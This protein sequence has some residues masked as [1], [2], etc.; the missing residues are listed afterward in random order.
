MANLTI[1]QAFNMTASDDYIWSPQS[2]NSTQIVTAANGGAIY[3]VY[4]GNFGFPSYGGVTGTMT[5]FTHNINGSQA[6]VYTGNLD[7]ATVYAH[8]MA[9]G[10]TQ[11][12]YAYAFSG[13]DLIMGSS[14]NDVLKGYAGKDSIDGG[15]G[16]D[17]VVYTG[18]YADYTVTKYTN[19]ITVEDKISSRDGADALKNIEQLKFADQTIAVSAV[20]VPLSATYASTQSHLAKYNVSMLAASDF[21]MSNL[22]NVQYMHDVC[23]SVGVTN[24]MIADIVSNVLPG[25]TSKQV[26]DFF[27]SNGVNSSDLD[28][29]TGASQ[30]TTATAASQTVDVH[31][32]SHDSNLSVSLNAG[33]GSYTFV[34]DM[35]KSSPVPSLSTNVLGGTTLITNF[36]SDDSIKIIN[37]D[38]VYL[39]SST[40]NTSI[41]VFGLVP[42]ME[43]IKLVG[44]NSSVYDVAG[45]N[46]L[47]VGDIVIV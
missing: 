22:N 10:D 8:A 34:F 11:S 43:T 18:N 7:A 1:N 2:Y 28:S 26:S 32:L 25:V 16:T 38:E 27:T 40:T 20:G 15:S 30:N 24:Q 23:K 5:S 46:E 39:S 44:L 45:F 29:S 6:F 4:S 17:T 12:T 9:V 3:D 36:G 33:A 13:N 35:S 47:S 42:S 41:N 21:I 14:G 19:G 37:S 31:S